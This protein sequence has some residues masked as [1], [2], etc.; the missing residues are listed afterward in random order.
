M[1][2]KDALKDVKNVSRV[3]NVSCV[4]LVLYIKVIIVTVPK[5]IILQMIDAKNAIL[6]VKRVLVQEITVHHVALDKF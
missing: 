5:D 3:Q 1:I 6:F 2:V 4:Q